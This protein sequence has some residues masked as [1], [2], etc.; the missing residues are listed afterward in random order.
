MLITEDAMV[1]EYAQRYKFCKKQKPESAKFICSTDEV[2]CHRGDMPTCMSRKYYRIDPMR[3]L[4]DYP[5]CLDDVW[6]TCD[7]VTQTYCRLDQVPTCQNRS[8]YLPADAEAAWICL[9]TC[10]LETHVKCA[11]TPESFPTCEPAAF[12]SLMGVWP[13]SGL[14]RC[15]PVL[16]G[17]CVQSGA[18]CTDS[19]PDPDG[20]RD[21]LREFQCLPDDVNAIGDERG[22]CQKAKTTL[23]DM[24]NHKGGIFSYGST[25]SKLADGDGLYIAGQPLFISCQLP[26]TTASD[27]VRPVFFRDGV[28]TEYLGTDGRPLTTD[29]VNFDPNELIQLSFS[30][31]RVRD[32]TSFTC[33]WET[34]VELEDT[35]GK[36]RVLKTWSALS[37]RVTITVYEPTDYCQFAPRRDEEN[38]CLYCE[39]NTVPCHEFIEE[40]WLA[41][42]LKLMAES[43]PVP[44][45]PKDA[46]G[47]SLSNEEA[48]GNVTGPEKRHEGCYAAWEFMQLPTTDLDQLRPRICRRRCP[49][50]GELTCHRIQGFPDAPPGCRSADEFAYATGRDP[51]I[52]DTDVLC[53][54][55]G[56]NDSSAVFPFSHVV[57]L[58]LSLL[59]TLNPTA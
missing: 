33:R 11:R 17:G 52:S 37:N 35:D 31:L 2:L 47:K 38:F 20:G 58:I 22:L 34:W 12:Y 50:L 48:G 10:P 36:R 19:Q 14:P 27:L 53:V 24:R 7:P 46:N 45:T 57:V 44:N 21:E 56:G 29:R 25:E 4:R 59:Y 15:S 18:W 8:E 13:T 23:L 51:L 3:F 1:K 40:P 9:T 54:A 16:S 30:A 42:K 39:P 5:L 43:T 6:G 55:L 32:S 28:R 41:D 49:S 26:G